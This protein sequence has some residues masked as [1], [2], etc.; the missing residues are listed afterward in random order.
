MLKLRKVFLKRGELP[1]R[2]HVVVH[3]HE[4]DDDAQ[5]RLVGKLALGLAQ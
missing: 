1:E 4:T 3:S 2:L 5:L